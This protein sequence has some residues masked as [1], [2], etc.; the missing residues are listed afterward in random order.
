MNEKNEVLVSCIL[1]R[2]ETPTGFTLNGSTKVHKSLSILAGVTE[3]EIKNLFAPVDEAFKSFVDAIGKATMENKKGRYIAL[4]KNNP[5]EA[6]LSLLIECME[7]MD[8]L[9]SKRMAKEEG[10]HLC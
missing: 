7:Y 3:K 4:D 5:K 8:E 1:K 6:F 10:E 2:E 9:E